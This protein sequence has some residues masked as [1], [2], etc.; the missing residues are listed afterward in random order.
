[1]SAA[2]IASGCSSMAAWLGVVDDD[3]G[4]A[5]AERALELVGVLD[6]RQRIAPWLQIEDRGAAAGIVCLPRG[7]VAG[8]A[9]RRQHL[10][11]PALEPGRRI[12]AGRK[13][14]KAERLQALVVGQRRIG[15]VPDRFADRRRRR[16][17]ADIGGDQRYTAHQI[18][19][20]G[21]EHARDA[22]AEGMAGDE[23]G[24]AAVVFDYRRDV[25]GAVM[26][27]RVRRRTAACTDAARLRPQHAIAGGGDPRSHDVEVGGAAAERWQ[28]RDAPARSL[29][30]HFDLDVAA[31]NDGAGDCG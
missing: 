14:G 26:Q 27:V 20:V 29:R 4:H 31:L 21:R 18:G 1:M 11:M 7:A 23:R 6:M 15:A 13:E 30:Q 25:G 9:L 12:V 17:V 8:D 28:Q 3:H 16:R 24:L 5:V 22:V 10:R 19:P 2:L